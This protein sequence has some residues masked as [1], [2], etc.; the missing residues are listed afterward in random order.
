[1]ITFYH[2]DL[3]DTCKFVTQDLEEMQQH[4]LTHQTVAANVINI[5][6]NG[7]QQQARLVVNPIP[8]DD[9]PMVKL[10]FERGQRPGKLQFETIGHIEAFETGAVVHINMTDID[11]DDVV[12]VN[13]NVEVDN[14]EDTGAEV[15]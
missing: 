9:T 4:E 7:V 14:E 8:D 12:E 11:V 15:N 13:D 10:T 1:M 6:S 3:D 5:R 2:C